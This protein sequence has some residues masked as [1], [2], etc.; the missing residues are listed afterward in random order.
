M[1]AAGSVALKCMLN[2]DFLKDNLNYQ[3]SLII[4]Y[5][6]RNVRLESCGPMFAFIQSYK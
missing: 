5:Y 4:M 6:T 3:V 2:I 1:Y